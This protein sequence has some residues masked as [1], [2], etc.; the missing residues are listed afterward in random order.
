MT[1]LQRSVLLVSLEKI[2]LTSFTKMKPIMLR[3]SLRLS[4]FCYVY[5][6]QVKHCDDL[7]IPANKSA[8][9]FLFIGVFATIGRVGGGFLCNIKCVKARIIFQAAAFIM[10]TSTMIMTLAKTY[11]ALVPC[12][13]VFSLADGMTITTFIIE[14]LNSV[15]ES[16]KTSAFGFTLIASG[17]FAVSSPPLSGTYRS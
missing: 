4:P 5:F 9:L 16:K 1:V 11:G 15:E 13:I 17:V 14:C 2:G 7:G 12:V 10:G 8:I 3:L 6:G